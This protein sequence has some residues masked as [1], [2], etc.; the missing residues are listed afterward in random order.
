MYVSGLLQAAALDVVTQPGWQT[1]LRG[2]RQQ[3]RARRDLLVNSLR[4]HAPTA[5]IDHVPTGGLNLWVRLPDGTDL[6]RL[7]RDCERGGVLIAPGTEW[8]PAE[9]DRAVPPAQLLRPE[10]GGLPRRGAHPRRGARPPG[11]MRLNPGIKWS[12]VRPGCCPRSPALGGPVVGQHGNRVFGRTELTRLLVATSQ[13]AHAA[14]RQMHLRA[15]ALA[16]RAL[17]HRGVVHLSGAVV[18][19]GSVCTARAYGGVH[20]RTT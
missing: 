10:P 17:V 16:R 7:A 11:T 2:L 1:H 5:H 14:R 13:G 18:V 9:P 20:E 15:T 8:F 6:D 19:G 4:E 3:L 12:E